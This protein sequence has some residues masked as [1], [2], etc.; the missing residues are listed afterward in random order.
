MVDK[1]DVG[2]CEI[3]GRGRENRFILVFLEW[4]NFR[5]LLGVLGE[6]ER[7]VNFERRFLDV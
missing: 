7:V 3:L 5:L 2:F 1:C 6:R 4:R